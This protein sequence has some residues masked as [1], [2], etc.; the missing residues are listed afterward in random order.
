MQTISEYT[1]ERE[2]ANAVTIQAIPEVR[3]FARRHV[4]RLQETGYTALVLK[5]LCREA[6]SSRRVSSEAA[7]REHA[8]ALNSGALLEGLE[9]FRTALE[10][11]KK[12]KLTTKKI[13]H[14][15]GKHNPVNTLSVVEQAN[16]TWD[17]VVG[18]LGR[19]ADTDRPLS[20]QTLAGSL[21]GRL[22]NLTGGAQEYGELGYE[23]AALLLLD[24]F[25]AATGWLEERSGEARMMSKT[26]KPNTYA[27]TPCFVS[28]V[29]GGGMPADFSERRPMLVPPVPWT[30]RATHGGYLGSEIP[31]VRGTSRAIGSQVIVDALNALQATAFRVNRRV[32]EVAETFHRNAENPSK[33]MVLGRYIEA[34]HDQGEHLQRAK[35]IR[36]ALTISAMRELLDA[37][38]FYFPWNL[39]WRGRMYPATTIISPQGADLC[40][41][42]LEFAEPTPLGRDGVRWLAI[43]L[44]SLWGEDKIMVDG[45]KVNRTP[46]EREEWT[47][48]HEDLILRVARDPHTYTD[49]QQADKPYQ[50]LAA[51]FE[52]A[53]VL[54]EGD[55]FRSR[56]AGAQDGSCSG[57]QMLAG[58]TRD[59]SA[60]RMVNLVPSPRG[61]DYYG[62]M[63]EA[64]SN[65][66]C[67]LVDDADKDAMRH[68]EF[69]S[70]YTLDRNLLK[71]PSM[72]KVYSAGTY[73]FGE[74]VRDKTGAP[75]HEAMWLASQINA[76]FADVAPGMLR[77]MSYLQE[78][79]CV[80]T[81]HG[82]PL[83]WTTPAG[84]QV[85]QARH[86][87][88]SLRV[89]TQ[90]GDKTTRKSRMFSLET[91][92]LS[93]KAQAA[94]VAPNFVHGV[95]AA[96]MAM[97]VNALHAKG[98]RNFWMIHDSFGAP[99]AQCGAVFETTREQFV[100]LMSVD[101]L[102]KWTED[103][104]RVLPLEVIE[105]LPT[106]PEYGELDLNEVK[107][108]LYSWL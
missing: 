22:R 76:C 17:A 26:R 35:T 63:A 40:K 70:D 84:L 102:R 27:I 96:H 20:V 52:W 44:C 59:K 29:L 74:Q 104:T 105:K 100:E 33:R 6:E 31:A 75:D 49:W 41:G 57:V 1:R 54:E 46:E 51:C 18:M 98:V 64:L 79:S 14:K 37:E 3:P 78:V 82:M 87:T 24:H 60:G 34:R 36:S 8:Q 77:A 107:E 68:L 47:R 101:L 90:I 89:E 4:E 16:A 2:Q 28:E 25:I 67:N 39:C 7:L 69:W 108:S 58:M 83:L 95:D 61:D 106:I 32:L 65:R 50:F 13:E 43:H 10:T 12:T 38:A 15:G 30:V 93:E 99:F 53:G 23:R 71:A 97:T 62:R 103:V 88:R 94:G 80:L 86:T 5:Q 66:L 91:D 48:Q 11:A 56:L 42:C 55:A 92:E 73:T 81:A 72:T 85:E 45:Q 19:M 21:G 9:A